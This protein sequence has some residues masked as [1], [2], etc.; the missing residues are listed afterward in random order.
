MKEMFMTNKTLPRPWYD[1]DDPLIPPSVHQFTTGTFVHHQIYGD[2]I[3]MRPD[4]YTR[5][6]C[7]RVFFADR[8]VIRVLAKS[9]VHRRV[10]SG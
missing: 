6:D 9:L 2:G 8:G 3:V 10:G 4:R 5:E 1:L 7:N